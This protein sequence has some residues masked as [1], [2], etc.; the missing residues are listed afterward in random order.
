MRRLKKLLRGEEGVALITAMLVTMVVLFLSV[1]VVQLSVH[2]QQQSG[3]DRR[4]VQAVAAAEA[5][6]DYYFSYLQKFSDP[7]PVC[8]ASQALPTTPPASFTVTPT[9]YDASGAVMACPYST[10]TVPAAVRVRSVG[11]AGNDASRRTMEAYA[12]LLSE[13]AATFDNDGAL[14]GQNNITFEANA[15]IGGD[16]FSDADI[17][18]N[19]NVSV[20]SNSIIYGSIFA[21]GTI[22][23]QSG[24]EIRKD[25]HAGQAVV[26]KNNTKIAGNATS[27]TSSITGGKVFGNARA[28]TNITSTV[29]GTSTPNTLSDPPPTRSF[30]LFTYN[31]ADWTALGY[32]VHTY[33]N[34]TQP[35]TDINSWWGSGSGSHLLRITGG[36]TLSFTG[37]YSIRG[38]IAIVTD[39][40][41]SFGPSARFTAVGG[42]WQTF[43][44]G[45]LNGASGCGISFASNAGI[46]A[47]LPAMLYTPSNC[48]IESLSNTYLNAGQIIGGTLIFKHTATFAYQRLEVPGVGVGGF[49]QDVTYKREVVTV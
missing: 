31:S 43:L 17:Y 1:T 21:Q 41:I 47:N 16:S 22:S 20:K 6:I 4:R 25:V 49:K 28:G 37:T 40:P 27:S 44:F 33:N 24:S 14:F 36:C 15:Q 19:G 42:P 18:S 32:T 26:L 35:I 7:V 34:C 12:T 8:S 3:N 48:T 30:P 46:G 39:G 29:F 23:I 9:F 2:N 11:W 5:G 45:G 38:N 13:P 10:T